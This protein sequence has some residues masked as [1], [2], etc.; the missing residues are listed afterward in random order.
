M[1]KRVCVLSLALPIQDDPRTGRQ[2]QAL[3]MDYAVT[4][5]GFGS[6]AWD[7]AA[8]ITWKP[9]ERRVSRLRLLL[10]LCLIALGRLFPPVYEVFYWTRPRYRQA[11]A[12]AL[13]SRA[14]AYHAS[15][16]AVVPIAARAA[17]ATGAK[18]VFDIDEYWPLFEE[19]SRLWRIFF[20]PF[21]HYI[22][23]RYARHVDRAMNVAPAFVERYQAEYGIDSILVYN[24]PEYQSVPFHPTDPDAIRLIHHGSS[25]PDRR[26]EVLIDMIAL[27][28]AR[29][30]LHFLLGSANPAYVDKLRQLADQRAPGRVFFRDTVTYD[31]V[32]ASIADCDIEVAFMAPTTYTWLMTLPN[33]LFE[34]MNAG[35]A[36]LVAPS[37]S[38]AAVVREYGVGWVASDFTAQALADALNPLTVEDIMGKRAAA[39][40]A[41]QQ[42]NAGTEL[43]KVRAL[44]RA[45][46]SDTPPVTG[47]PAPPR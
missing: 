10:E 19:S 28:D 41:A 36:V 17:Q 4:V 45:L 32:V 5:I 6:P 14:D 1:K 33:K 24:A 15:D 29:F 25:Q 43:A 31:R 8:H 34:A 20:A 23:K 37:P 13:E 27:L 46:W 16:W 26:L 35:L 42:V 12:Y 18:V 40:H 11:L 2:V 44:Y 22:L 7:S 47:A 21:T 38:M 30:T 3:A 9:V 39:L